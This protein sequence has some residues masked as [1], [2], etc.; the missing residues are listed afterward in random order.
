[1]LVGYGPTTRES[2]LGFNSMTRSPSETKRPAPRQNP[3]PKSR[4]LVHIAPP[5]PPRQ[6][7]TDTLPLIPLLP[8]LLS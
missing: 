2:F 3:Y 7:Q 5:L 8:L 4:S 6:A 1:M